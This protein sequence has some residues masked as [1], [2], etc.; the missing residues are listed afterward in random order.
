M[1]VSQVFLNY[2]N[3]SCLDCLAAALDSEHQ[4]TGFGCHLLAE[5]GTVLLVE[6]DQRA[7]A[8]Q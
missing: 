1:K 7:A 5:R 3:H 4:Y 2:L 6:V 8:G